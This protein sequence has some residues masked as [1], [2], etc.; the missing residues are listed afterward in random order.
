MRIT[1]ALL[2]SKGACADQVELFAK[3]FPRGVTLTEAVC[4]KHAHEFE[5]HW[6]AKHLLSYTAWEEYWKID[7]LAR[8]EYKKATDLAL[9]EYA[10]VK[11]LARAEYVKV[12]GL[13]RAEYVKV[14]GLA[15]AEYKK[16]CSIAFWKASKL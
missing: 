16:Q 10:K 13:A 6:A 4:V 2:E 12:E 5:W 14:K 11:G 9:V 7:S 1:K 3:L 8:A 15:W